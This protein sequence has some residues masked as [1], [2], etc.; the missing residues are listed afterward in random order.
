MVRRGDTCYLICFKIFHITALKEIACD[1]SDVH[2]AP[3]ITAFVYVAHTRPLLPFQIYCPET[4][5][6]SSVEQIYGAP[7][8]TYFRALCSKQHWILAHFLL[9]E[10]RM[11][12][13][14]HSET[15]Y[16]A[17]TVEICLFVSSSKIIKMILGKEKYGD[18][19]RHKEEEMLRNKGETER[20][21]VLRGPLRNG[22]LWA[23]SHFAHAL[24]HLQPHWDIHA[25][26]QK[27]MHP[28]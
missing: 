12:A 26:T 23:I 16:Q 6:A 3:L 24:K 14:K 2:C 20:A 5:D 17:K 11:M 10:A 13:N 4:M 21:K 28:L 18:R 9:I 22:G 25:P 7:G 27:L 19:G 15:G 8:K 1:C